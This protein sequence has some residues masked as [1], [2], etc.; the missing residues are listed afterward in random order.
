[1]KGS[2]RLWE[3]FTTSL[4]IYH[5]IITV[6]D[7]TLKARRI[8]TSGTTKPALKWS[9]P[10]AE[11]EVSIRHLPLFLL[12]L[13]QCLFS[14]MPVIGITES[15]AALL[16]MQLNCMK[17]LGMAVDGHILLALLACAHDAASTNVGCMQRMTCFGSSRGT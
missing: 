8:A 1:M 13:A 11:M 6:K 16:L 2:T 14:D 4:A 10:S 7:P 5:V 9:C 17:C 15:L 12:S 3:P